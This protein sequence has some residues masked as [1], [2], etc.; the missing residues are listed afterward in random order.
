MKHRFLVAA[1]C[2]AAVATAL[3]ASALAR[4]GWKVERILSGGTYSIHSKALHCGPSKFGT[5]TIIGNAR[6]NGK[7]LHEVATLD[8]VNDGH[9]RHLRIVT[10]GGTLIS[11][12]PRRQ[13]QAVR[14]IVASYFNQATVTVVSV[15][16]NQ[17]TT[18]FRFPGGRSSTGHV[19]FQR[20]TC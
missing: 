3:P 17:L 5:Y 20:T 15:N 16:G 4:Q 10:I 14:S 8:I 11:S 13:R 9:P 1:G 18:S 6:I 12:L 2:A 19:T 7:T